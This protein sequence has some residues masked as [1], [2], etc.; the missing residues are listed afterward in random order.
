LKFYSFNKLHEGN[1]FG[2]NF[3]FEVS[4]DHIFRPHITTNQHEL[5]LNNAKRLFNLIKHDGVIFSPLGIESIGMQEKNSNQ[6][7]YFDNDYTFEQT[8]ENP[9]YVTNAQP[10]PHFFIKIEVATCGWLTCC[11]GMQRCKKEVGKK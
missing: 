5:D 3:G 10:M 6:I 2:Q 7:L 1:I 11:V 8:M 9:N 4:I